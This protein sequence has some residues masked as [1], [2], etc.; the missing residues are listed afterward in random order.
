MRAAKV[1]ADGLTVRHLLQHR[2][3]CAYDPGNDEAFVAEVTSTPTRRWKPSELLD[4]ALDHMGTWGPPGRAVAYCDTNFIVLGLAAEHVT[5]RRLEAQYRAR[6]LTPLGMRATYLEGH[7]APRGPALSH[8]FIG[9]LD[10]GRFDGSFD[11]GGGGLV[12]TAGDLGIFIRA[13][14]DGRLFS[15]P[16]TL[17]AILDTVDAQ[18]GAY[19]LGIAHGRVA[20]DEVWGHAGFWGSFMYLLPARGLAITGTLNQAS[21][22]TDEFVAPV[23]ATVLKGG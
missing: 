14:L 6:I 17:A 19:G 22:S 1:P 9:G 10:A 18:K 7:G 5:G 12:S 20:G 15:K 4:W 3:G 11:W 21:A 8:P 13:L 23:A 16:A 2:S